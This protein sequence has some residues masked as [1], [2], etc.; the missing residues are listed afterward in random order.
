MGRNIMNSSCGC[1][2]HDQKKAILR[3]TCNISFRNRLE[4]DEKVIV[5]E[6]NKMLDLIL[7]DQPI[8]QKR[9]RNVRFLTDFKSMREEFHDTSNSPPISFLC[10]FEVDHI[11]PSKK[12]MNYGLRCTPN[13]VRQ[14]K[15][16]L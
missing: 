9:D 4:S 6:R 10:Q 5:A 12:T 16:I 1:G 3:D 8:G 13:Y 14:K 2:H 7:H 11:D 15:E